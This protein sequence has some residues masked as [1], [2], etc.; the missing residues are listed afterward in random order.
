MTAGSQTWVRASKLL[1]AFAVV[2]G[3]AAVGL[4]GPPLDS[5]QTVPWSYV[6][7]GAVAHLVTGMA[8]VAVGA[9]FSRPII[10]RTAWAILPALGV[11]LADIV[12]P[13]ATP[14]RQILVLF[15]ETP[16]KDLTG[17]AARDL[18]GDGRPDSGS[19]RRVDL[20]DASEELRNRTRSRLSQSCERSEVLAR[21]RA[22]ESFTGDAEYEHVQKRHRHREDAE[23]RY[24]VP[25]FVVHQ[26]DGDQECPED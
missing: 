14:T 2:V 26:K 11:D 18:R 17:D 23:R 1:A 7:A 8:G 10:G 6:A 16:V 21:L 4:I 20:P 22:H 15:N 25:Q 24:D 13:H 12:I 19:L 9:V 3:L 5:S